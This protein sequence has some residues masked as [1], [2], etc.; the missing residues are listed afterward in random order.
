MPNQTE[1]GLVLKC[2]YCKIEFGPTELIIYDTETKRVFHTHAE[3]KRWYEL[4]KLPFTEEDCHK[5][6]EITSKTVLEKINSEPK[7]SRLEYNWP[8]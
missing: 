7:E 8:E 4:H 2:D 5:L 6:E 1:K 3:A